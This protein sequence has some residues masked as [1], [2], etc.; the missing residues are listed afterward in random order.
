[1]SGV[2]WKR[3]LFWGHPRAMK[4]VLIFSGKQWGFLKTKVNESKHALWLTAVIS[5]LKRL[6]A[7]AMP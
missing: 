7:G 2:N 1:M 4:A 6:E 3:P 5:A